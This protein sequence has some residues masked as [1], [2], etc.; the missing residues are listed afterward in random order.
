MSTALVRIAL[1][2][3]KIDF[4][5]SKSTAYSL[6]SLFLRSETFNKVKQLQRVV[7]NIYPILDKSTMQS[8]ASLRV[9]SDSVS[10][11]VLQPQK[12]FRYAL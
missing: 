10:T 4:S 9:Q 6:R 1:K 8:H 7:V 5:S 3:S 11:T 2:L 12:V